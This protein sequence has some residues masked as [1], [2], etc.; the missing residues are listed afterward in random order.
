MRYSETVTVSKLPNG[1]TVVTDTVPNSTVLYAYINAFTGGQHDPLDK[2][3][4]AH[5]SEHMIG[6]GVPGFTGDQLDAINDDRLLLEH[7]KRTDGKATEYFAYGDPVDVDNYLTEMATAITALAYDQ[8]ALDIE[9]GRIKNE[10]LN[11]YQNINRQDPIMAGRALYGNGMLSRTAG[12]TIEGFDNVSLADVR[13]HHAGMHV[14]N[15]MFLL[16]TGCW[17]HDQTLAWAEKN[18]AHLE[19]G[20]R[21]PQ[22][23]SPFNISDIWL[24]REGHNLVSALV[25]FPIPTTW[26]KSRSEFSVIWKILK[27]VFNKIANKHGL[28]GLYNGRDYAH[29]AMPYFTISANCAPKQWGLIISETMNF[30]DTCDDLI[31]SNGRSAADYMH[32]YY[33]MDFNAKYS[34]LPYRHDNIRLNMSFL[35]DPFAQDGFIKGCL[36]VD[37]EY[38][39]RLLRQTLSQNPA[40]F[41][42]GAIQ[43]CLPTGRDIMMRNIIDPSGHMVR[44]SSFSPNPS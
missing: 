33:T 27:P 11:A 23:Y 5:L 18:L 19:E 31:R 21:N 29:P 24:P 15:N 26:E 37:P 8:E 41:Y 4:L 9:K 6:Y 22:P 40:T 34:A 44:R 35:N 32:K 20:K 7:N 28:Y 13:K 10:I 3:G 30:L 42:T 25:M 16:A 14:A 39:V 17:T 2:S 43:D 12:G 38:L 1:L 36:E